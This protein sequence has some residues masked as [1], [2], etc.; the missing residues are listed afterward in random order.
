MTNISVQTWTYLSLQQFEC[1]LNLNSV[2]NTTE[3]KVH[4]GTCN[5]TDQRQKPLRFRKIKI[6]DQ[7]SPKPLENPQAN[8]VWPL[9]FRQSRELIIKYHRNPYCSNEDY[10]TMATWWLLDLIA[11][12]SN[13][14]LS[15]TKV[16]LSI[17]LDS[18]NS[19]VTQWKILI[20]YNFQG[21]KRNSMM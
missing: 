21:E 4:G 9:P 7:I 10:H 20:V 19:E 2:M 14:L 17:V 8:D 11:K 12:H 18:Y 5:L 16:G 13:F 1:T 6:F 3:R 15:V